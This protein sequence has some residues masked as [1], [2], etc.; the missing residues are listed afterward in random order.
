MR[1]I[2]WKNKSRRQNMI[3]H[4]TLAVSYEAHWNNMLLKS[5][6]TECNLQPSVCYLRWMS[7]KPD[8][9]NN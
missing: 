6:R 9:V 2:C 8:G 3:L 7:L 1:L 4:L 5:R